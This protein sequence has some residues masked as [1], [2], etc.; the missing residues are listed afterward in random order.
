[1]ASNDTSLQAISNL[2]QAADRDHS[3]NLSRDE[4]VG[5]MQQIKKGMVPSNEEVNMCMALMDKDSDGV[6]TKEEFTSAMAKWLGLDERRGEFGSPSAQSRKRAVSDLTKFFKQFDTVGDFNKQQEL[7][8]QRERP[9]I[10]HAA[11]LHEFPAY[12]KEEKLAFHRSVASIVAAGKTCLLAELHSV[13][14][15]VVLRAAHK[16][17]DLLA[18][19]EVFHD[20]DERCGAVLASL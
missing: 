2:F 13:D 17:K 12:C 18:V 5:I 14:W 20:P 1:M 10:D 16:V 19:V 4:I 15:N 7:I 3:G 8:L 11:L 9:E 6:I